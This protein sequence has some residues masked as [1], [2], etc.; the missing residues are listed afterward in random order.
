MVPATQSTTSSYTPPFIY[1]EYFTPKSHRFPE[2][3][4]DHDNYTNHLGLFLPH[5]TV[6]GCGRFF[7]RDV[8]EA[9]IQSVAIYP[10]GTEV[11]LSDGR[12]GIVAA[13]KWN[14]LRIYRFNTICHSV[15]KPRLL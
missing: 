3:L 13:N 2:Q 14:P 8:V 11:M 1:N 6:G 12:E 9:F 10:S 15:I 7:D 4:S 5:P